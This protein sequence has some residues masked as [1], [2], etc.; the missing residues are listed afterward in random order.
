[1]ALRGN[2]KKWEEKEIR[3][4]GR[5]FINKKL[6]LY[7]ETKQSYNNLKQKLNKKGKGKKRS[8]ESNSGPSTCRTV[9]LPLHH[10]LIISQRNGKKGLAENQSNVPSCIFFI[11]VAC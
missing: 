3:Q 2:G 9:P 5:K 11:F 8:P 1:M 7:K 10:M 4:K 6:T